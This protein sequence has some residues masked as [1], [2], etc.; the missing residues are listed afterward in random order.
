[1][2]KIRPDEIYIGSAAIEALIQYCRQKGHMRLLLVADRNTHAALGQRVEG[3]LHHA[4][5]DLKSVLLT[6][7]EVVAD[8]HNIL[9][10]LIAANNE[11]RTFLAVGSGT[12]TDLTRFTSHRTGAHFLSMPTAPSVDGFTSIGAPTIVAGVKK[13][14]VAQPPAAIF[15]DIE[16]LAGAPR[17]LLAA[18]FGDM[19]GKFT[20]AADFRLGHLLWDEPFEEEIAQRTQQA[21]QLCVA[22]VPQIGSS[23]HEGAE[24]LFHNLVESGYCMLDFGDSRPASGA[25]HHISHFVEM[26]LLQQGQKALL[27]GAKVGVA[28]VRI[29]ELY[30]RI[31][32]LSQQEAATLIAQAKQPDAASEEER[33]R[34][35]YGDL[36]D[37]MLREQCAFTHMPA[38]QYAALQ[39][40]IVEQWPQIQSIAQGVPSAN[41]LTGWLKRVGAPT[42]PAELGL[43]QDEF[44]LAYN[45]GHYLRQRFT[46]RKLM[47]MF[48]NA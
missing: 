40:E 18:G 41:E 16:T 33:I 37:E 17:L 8:A 38:D 14:L 11:G 32:Q 22:N 15:V 42:T 35:A 3:A 47:H 21:A 30:D 46:I 6:S 25:E 39:E 26:R 10:I 27:H 13:T 4:G 24:V 44:E 5:F 20:S 28:T 43:S 9:Q 29:A 1:M 19:M 45:H 34:S 7:D 12:I 23:T 48:F 2:V 36:A 31:K